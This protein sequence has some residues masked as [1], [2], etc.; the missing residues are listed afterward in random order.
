[1]AYN[2]QYRLEHLPPGFEL[3]FGTLVSPGYADATRSS[4]F[5]VYI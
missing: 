3:E 5:L 1:M 2:L 4:V